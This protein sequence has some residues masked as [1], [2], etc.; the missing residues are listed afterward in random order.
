MLSRFGLIALAMTALAAARPALATPIFTFTLS[1]LTSS[2]GPNGTIDLD[3]TVL[4]TGAT[5]INGVSEE[6]AELTGTGTIFPFETSPFGF[7]FTAALAAINSTHTLAPGASVTFTFDDLSFAGAT[8]GTYAL[9]SEADLG[10]TDTLGGSADF[11]ITSDPTVTITPE[12]APLVLL[13]TGMLGVLGMARR[14]LG[15]SR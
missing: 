15:I 9:Y 3:A 2:S 5:T 7:D 8:P 1:P 6:G 13:G 14:R 12:P 11:A 10:L 4:N